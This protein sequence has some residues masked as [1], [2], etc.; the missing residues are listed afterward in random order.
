[1]NRPEVMKLMAKMSNAYPLLK[2]RDQGIM[3]DLWTECLQDAD[4]AMINRAFTR[5]Y[6]DDLRNLPPT[7]GNLLDYIPE[8]SR[9]PFVGW[10]EDE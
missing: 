8:S 10:D 9:H 5:Y 7:P 6:R 1:M 4:A 2:D 3:I